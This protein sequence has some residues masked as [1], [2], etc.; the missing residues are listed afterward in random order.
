MYLYDFY[1]LPTPQSRNKFKIDVNLEFK[2]ELIEWPS[3]LN[4][5]EATDSVLKSFAV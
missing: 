3:Y 4:E 5:K 1:F 2:Y